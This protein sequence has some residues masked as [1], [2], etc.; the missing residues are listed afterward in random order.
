[1]HRPPCCRTSR[2]PGRRQPRSSCRLSRSA[3]DRTW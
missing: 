2:V 1:M 3:S